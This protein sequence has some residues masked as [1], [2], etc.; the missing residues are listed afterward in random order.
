ML[1]GGGVTGV[2]WETG[3][4]AGLAARGVQL[5][6]A[7]LIVGTSAG[8]VVGAQLAW[9]RSLDQMYADQ[10]KPGGPP[11]GAARLRPRHIALYVWAALR[12]R[13]PTAARARIGRLA[14]SARTM[15]EAER[16]AVIASRVPGDEWPARRLM[17]TAVDT[18][19]GESRAFEAGPGVGLIDAV[20]ASCAVPGVWPPVTIGGRRWMDGGMRSPANADLAAGCDAVVVLP[21]SPRGCAAPACRAR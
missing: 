12:H 15:P 6:G 1:G 2:A 18:G 16:R 14:T 10:L 8:S 20:A 21:R 3:V 17:I 13:D 19:S 11:G 4:L 9:G 7:D 5:G